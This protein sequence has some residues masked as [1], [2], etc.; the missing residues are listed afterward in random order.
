MLCA[1]AGVLYA[2]VYDYRLTAGDGTVESA[3]TICKLSP[4]LSWLDDSLD[5]QGTLHACVR[6]AVTYSYMRSWRA[7]RLAAAD[8]AVLLRCGRRWVLRYLLWARRLLEKHDTKYVANRLWVNDLCVWVQTLP[9]ERLGEFAE[10]WAHH[11][12]AVNPSA[13]GWSLRRLAA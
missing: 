3:W 11:V 4:A 6:R 13:T 10:E 8:S 7:A 5:A 2:I 9:E 1:L 12:C